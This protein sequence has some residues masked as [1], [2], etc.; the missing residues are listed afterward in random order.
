MTRTLRNVTLTTTTGDYAITAPVRTRAASDAG[1][2]AAART[3]IGGLP[4]AGASLALSWWE[5]GRGDV[6]IAL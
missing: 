3:A 4:G 1:A 5:A 2:V 6:S